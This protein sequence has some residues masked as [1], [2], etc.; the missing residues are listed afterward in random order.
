MIHIK[1]D[2]ITKYQPE[3]ILDFKSYEPNDHKLVTQFDNI[4][5]IFKTSTYDNNNFVNKESKVIDRI[6]LVK[7][8]VNGLLNKLSK[9]NYAV[10]L[11]KILK[12]RIENLTMLNTIMGIIF[13]TII[14]APHMAS[15]YGQFLKD[16]NC[17][18]KWIFSDED[19]GKICSPRIII[20]NLCQ[21]KFENIIK[22]NIDSADTDNYFR[23]KNE[24]SG[25]VLLI[26]SMFNT[27][28]LASSVFHQCI[29]ELIKNTNENNIELVLQLLTATNTKLKNNEKEYYELYIRMLNDYYHTSTLTQRTKFNI[30]DYLELN[31]C[32]E[33]VKPTKLTKPTKPTKPTKLTKSG[34]STKATKADEAFNLDDFIYNMVKEY[35]NSNDM[36]EVV[37]YLDDENVKPDG[38]F[39]SILI[40]N[41]FDIKKNDIHKVITLI[42]TLV[43][44]E[45]ITVPVLQEGIDL[46]MQD[47]DDIVL[48]V[49]YAKTYMNNLME[50]LKEHG[51]TLMVE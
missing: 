47:M 44:R 41:I 6:V 48:D 40:D 18:S 13:N 36:D 17:K 43:Q 23:E 4:I 26:S 49:P 33:A 35:V 30:L 20:L 39:V 2:K 50:E 9:T 46:I 32:V 5:N 10:L 45:I 1:Q 28:I 12:L 21:N 37:V 42:S 19:T 15:I 27:G 7:K 38:E 14:S 31:D 16:I 24:R 34:K 11:D 3:F 25:I 51:F 29:T 22:N 8:E